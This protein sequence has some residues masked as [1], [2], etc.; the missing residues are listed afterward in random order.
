MRRRLA[1]AAAVALLPLLAAAG[2]VDTVLTPGERAGLAL[3]ITQEDT[4][5]VR[6][7]RT[8][9]L[10][11]G[12]QALVLEGVSRQARDGTAWLSG[13]GI[14]VHEQ[15]FHSA[16]LD[17]D[18]L[19]AAAVGQDVTVVWRDGAGADHEER[20]KVIA[21]G[22]QPVFQ[23]GTRLVAGTP[24]RILYD[25]LPPDVQ[26][27]PSYRAHI[28]TEATGRREVELAYL[29]GG[30]SW[31]ADYV[32]ELNPAED[33]LTLSAWATLANN[34]GTD[35][36][37][38]RIQVMAGDINLAGQPP[39]P[40]MQHMEKALMATAGGPVPPREVLGGYHL[41]S[42]AL[43][44]SLKDG[45]RKQVALMAPG[46][47]AVERAL[48]LD[49]L[50]AHAWRDRSPDQPDQ[51]PMTVLK[52]KNSGE[53]PLPAGTIRVFQR[54]QDGS[55]GFLGED[56]LTATPAGAPARI[57]LG[58]AFDVSVRR[59]QTDF[60]RVSAEVTEAAWE[61]RL[62]NAGSSPAR[63]TVRESF[64]GDW[65]VLEESARHTKENAFT[66]AWTVTVPAKGET[67]LSYRARVKG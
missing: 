25:S 17:A 48:V 20:A 55:V 26:L 19:L 24:A 65:L 10:D 30:L 39:G 67:M 12:P 27:L 13:N 61:V 57:V 35:Y 5:L 63:V 54:A 33:R 28:T 40:R 11:K 59:A 2:P 60:S 23:V 22:P 52:L 31:S 21:A 56:H 42:L 6:D 47:L 32:A 4:A 64:G 53:Q 62:A 29:T 44:V 45:D 9:T 41:Y 51:H 66:A 7:R 50:P 8:A 18:S 43:P 3:T 38:A 49:P 58:R 14:T 16:G 46:Q 15:S 36:P 37:N 34:S 1:L